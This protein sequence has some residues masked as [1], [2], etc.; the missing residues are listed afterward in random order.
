MRQWHTHPVPPPTHPP[1][2]PPHTH[3][4][5]P[6]THM[7]TTR[8]NGSL[9]TP[10][11]TPSAHTDLHMTAAVRRATMQQH[12]ATPGGVLV[13]FKS[14][15]LLEL[16]TARWETT[17]G[18]ARLYAEKRGNV[19]VEV[20]RQ[21]GDEFDAL[22]GA[23]RAAAAIAEEIGAP[24]EAL[25]SLRMAHERGAASGVWTDSITYIDRLHRGGAEDEQP[26]HLEELL[27]PRHRLPEIILAHG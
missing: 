1:T 23:Y 5:P 19:F 17:G 26:V 14:Y 18:R 4:S 13:F 20:R 22:V 8:H 25:A 11:I 3:T 24:E 9:H 27:H 6:T 2:R 12:A 15:Q 10:H 7:H 21:S 16:A